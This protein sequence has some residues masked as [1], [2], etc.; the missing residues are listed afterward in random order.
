MSSS[1]L[2]KELDR[3]N[4][5]EQ[6]DIEVEVSDDVLVNDH[7]VP[8]PRTKRKRDLLEYEEKL[9]KAVFKATEKAFEV[10]ASQ[11]KVQKALAENDHLRI[12]Q[13][14][15]R[16]IE[17]MDGELGNI[18][19]EV[20]NMKSEIDKISIRVEEMTP[21]MHH[22][23]VAENLRRRELGLPQL[24]LPFLVGE[25]PVGTDLPPIVSVNDIQDLS[26][27]EILRYLAGY[28][29]GHERHATTSSLKCI[30]RMTLGFTLAHELHFTFS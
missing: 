22:V 16:T 21:L 25:G 1:N 18:K 26:K 14:L 30:L 17:S 15:L 12:L 4:A 29:V 5:L 28:D 9:D 7:G 23:R 2:P 8:P 11:Y 20:R 3:M 24:T 10:R 13:S 6:K 27:S 19:S